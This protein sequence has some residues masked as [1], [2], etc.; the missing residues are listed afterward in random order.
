MGT[1]VVGIDG[2]PSA[3]AALAWAVED[4]RARSW[5]LRAVMCWD[6]LAQHHVPDTPI[7]FDPE[8][9]EAAAAAALEA[10]VGDAA[11]QPDV[12]IERRVVLDLA[13]RGLLESAA[14]ADLLVLGARGVGGFEAL[15]LGSTSDQCLRHSPVPVVIVRPGP[16]ANAPDEAAKVVVGFDGSDGSMRALDWAIEHALARTLHLEVLRSWDVPTSVVPFIESCEPIERLAQESVREAVARCEAAGLAG[17]VRGRVICS[18]AGSAMID[19]SRSAG[20]VV[21][22]SRG[23]STFKGLLLGSVSHRLASHASGPIAVI[24]AGV[25]TAPAGA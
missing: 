16:P 18:D 15:L 8:Y 25:R 4:A 10:F 24:P 14:D 7:A 23:R 2:S 19:A 21:V 17:R 9:D 12:P 5:A 20:L 11:G 3:A 6:Y 22:G 13:A 1:I